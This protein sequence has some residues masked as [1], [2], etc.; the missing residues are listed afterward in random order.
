MSATA[1]SQPVPRHV[2]VI[3]DGNGR[4]AA[5]R[6]RPRAIGHRAGARAVNLCI[7]FCIERGIQALTLFAF[8]SENWGRPAEEVGALMKLFLNALEREVGELHR[9]GVRVRFIGERGRFDPAIAARMQA[10]EALT[11]GNRRLALSIAA[12]YG[13]RQDIAR[14]ARELAVEVAAGRMSP[15]DIDEAA[16][17]ARLALADLPAPDLFIRTGGDL[18]I[19]NFLLWQLA[20]TELWFTDLLWPDLDA[21]TLQQALDAFASRERRFGLTGDQ[22]AVAAAPTTDTPTP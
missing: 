20:Y 17:A 9:R 11:A 3:M 14:A 8:S 16:L 6:K 7:D 13:G 19:S 18:R 5:R 2:A 22:V 1:T 12:S 4:W 10:A 21:A 15:D